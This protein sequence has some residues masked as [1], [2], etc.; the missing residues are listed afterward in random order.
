MLNK[1]TRCLLPFMLCLSLPAW[2]ACGGDDPDTPMTN[3]NLFGDLDAETQAALPLKAVTSLTDIGLWPSDLAIYGDYAYVVDSGNNAITRIHLT[4]F[5]VEKNYIDL[6]ADASPYAVYADAEDI[7]VALQGKGTVARISSA[8]PTDIATA[9]S[10]LRAPTAILTAGDALCIADSEYDYASPQNTKGSIHVITSQGAFTVPSS[11]PNPAFIDTISLN[12]TT[13]LLS[14]NAGVIDFATQTPPAKSCIDIWQIPQNLA[15]AQPANSVCVSNANLGRVTTLDQMLYVG[16]G[17][18][19]TLYKLPLGSLLTK[20][21]Q[22]TYMPILNAPKGTTTPIAIGDHLAVIDFTSDSISWAAESAPQTYYLTT[23]AENPVKGPI[24]IV[25]DAARKQ[26]LILN[27]L[28]ETIDV[29]A[30]K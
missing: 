15:S 27:S 21:A 4:D 13:Y 12:G 6:G 24:D 3:I 16:D 30:I 2:T 20:D 14:I 7:Y 17:M 1:M 25:Y 19:P 29:L 9:A 26:I 8:N 22:F 23:P 11:S 5:K 28:S 18:T 10:D